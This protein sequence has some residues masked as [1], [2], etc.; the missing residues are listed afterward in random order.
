MISHM[1]L[2]FKCF[3][4]QFL[5]INMQILAWLA[6]SVDDVRATALGIQ[7]KDDERCAKDDKHTHLASN[8]LSISRHSGFSLYKY[9]NRLTVVLIP[10]PITIQA[11]YSM[12]LQFNIPFDICKT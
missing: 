1:S 2:H 10:S 5:A 3:T 6:P 7:P 11:I 9:F 8:P 4:T 12:Y